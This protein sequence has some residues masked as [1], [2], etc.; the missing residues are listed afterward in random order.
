MSDASATAAEPDDFTLGSG[1][2]VQL[3]VSDFRS[4]MGEAYQW[5]MFSQ[6]N[7]E[8]IVGPDGRLSLPVIGFVNA[9]GR[10][11]AEVADEV[12]ARLQTRAGLT[13]RPDASIQIVKFRPFY[14]AGVVDKPGEYEYRPGMTVLQAVSIAGGMQRVAPDLF[15]GLEKDAL[16]ARGDLRALEGEPRLTRGAASAYRRRNHS[17]ATR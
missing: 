13:A 6:Q 15:I 7:E 10:T 9:Q 17:A 2:H 5:Q 12:S 4:G 16:S 11:A 14:V 8:F 3:R 1:D